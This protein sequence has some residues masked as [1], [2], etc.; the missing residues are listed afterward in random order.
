MNANLTR[1]TATTQNRLRSCGYVK[2]AMLIG[3]KDIHPRAVKLDNPP[4]QAAIMTKQERQEL[5]NAIAMDVIAAI[6]CVEKG[7]THWRVNGMMART[8][9]HLASFNPPCPDHLL[10]PGRRQFSASNPYIPKPRETDGK[11]KIVIRQVG[12]GWTFPDGAFISHFLTADK[13]AKSLGMVLEFRS[14]WR[15]SETE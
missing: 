1:I 5:Y 8:A 14:K 15:F 4:H 6:E 7:G 3:T 2:H 10:P 12:N 11:V 9:A 13:K